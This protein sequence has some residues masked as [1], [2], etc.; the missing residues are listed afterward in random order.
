MSRV[1][2]LTLC[3]Y[4]KYGNRIQ[5]YALQ[6][7]LIRMGHEVETIWI[8]RKGTS[9]KNHKKQVLCSSIS[10]QRKLKRL[11]DK[12][13]SNRRNTRYE[14]FRLFDKKYIKRSCFIANI[15]GLSEKAAAYFDYL[16]IGSDQVWNYDYQALETEVAE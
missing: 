5:N 15:D 9:L 12:C 3:G 6:T 2:I 1:G 7:I 10:L 8:E 14:R 11:A 16:I 4:G 13:L